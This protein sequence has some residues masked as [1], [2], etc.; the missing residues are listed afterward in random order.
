MTIQ[1][2]NSVA[3]PAGEGEVPQPQSGRRG[4]KMTLRTKLM[5]GFLVVALVTCALGVLTLITYR[6]VQEVFSLLEEDVVPGAISIMETETAIQGLLMEVEEMVL[7]RDATHWEY[8]LED[9]ARM[10][11]SVGEH[12]AIAEKLGGEEHQDMLDVK[13]QIEQIIGLANQVKDTVEADKSEAEITNSVDQLHTTA[14]ALM[15]VLEA[16]VAEHLTELVEAEK[17][18]HQA[19]TTGRQTVWVI[20]I[21]ALVLAVGVGFYT[22]KSV[23]NPI[24]KIASVAGVIAEGDLTQEIEVKGQDELGRLA[25]AF[26]HMTQELRNLIGQI[27]DHAQRLSTSAEELSAS[28]EQ[29]NAS[30]EQIAST[31]QQIAHGAQLQAEQVQATSKSIE[32]MAASTQQIADNTQTTNTASRQAKEVLIDMA[33]AFGGLAEKSKEI[34][35]IVTIIEK[36]A[37]Q[38]NLLAL[39]AAI[40]AARAGEHGKGFAVVADEVRKLA[41]NSSASV[42]EIADLSEEIQGEI[43]RLLASSEGVVEAMDKAVGLVEET[44]ASVQQQREGAERIVRAINEVASVAEENASGAEEVAAAIEEQAATMDQIT[45][46]AQ[47]LSERADSLWLAVNEF[48]LRRTEARCWEIMNC[49]PEHWQKC[50]AYQAEEDRCWFIEGTWCRGV[51]QGDARSKIHACMNCKAHIVMMRG[52]NRNP[53]PEQPRTRR[54]RL[55]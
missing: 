4:L 36:F 43:G 25:L 50:P 27:I 52:A 24:Q 29:M 51:E 30:G 35:Q 44:S 42:K 12:L 3:S 23:A 28:S 39:N 41:E 47:S 40:E 54:S 2:G 18:V 10:R 34:G 37:D 48:R 15:A 14:E 49:A 33:E 5:L 46:A 22:A 53:P 21:V 55:R 17:N 26:N 32:E 1:I 20:M 7:V 11:K 6:D 31:V 45:T 38:T 19:H 16:D 8:A 9:I 13:D